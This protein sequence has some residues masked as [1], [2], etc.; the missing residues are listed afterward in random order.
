MMHFWYWVMLGHS[1][2]KGIMVTN[3]EFNATTGQTYPVS[4]RN[5]DAGILKQLSG[6][7]SH[8]WGLT[9]FHKYVKKSRLSFSDM[10]MS[11][12]PREDEK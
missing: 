6:N 5:L 4:I 1:I 8:L 12:N 11:R 10:K 3:S 2:G 7:A 9:F